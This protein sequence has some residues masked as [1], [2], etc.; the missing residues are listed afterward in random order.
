LSRGQRRQL[1]HSSGGNRHAA[2][3]RGP[4]Y[5]N[6]ISVGCQ[7]LQINGDG[8]FDVALR[9]FQG[10]AL[11]VATWQCR[12]E[13]HVSAFRSLFVEDRIGEGLR[14]LAFHHLHCRRSSNRQSR[15]RRVPG[16]RADVAVGSVGMNNFRLLV[17]S[18]CQTRRS[19]FAAPLPWK[20]ALGLSGRIRLEAFAAPCEFR[21]LRR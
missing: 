12:N 4:L 16:E 13:C 17:A 8:L 1:R 5:G 20:R 11:G 7:A 3:E 6:G 18:A 9:I 15:V 21:T 2:L 14:S 10:L 19:N